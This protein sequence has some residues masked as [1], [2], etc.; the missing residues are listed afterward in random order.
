MFH[1]KREFFI[2]KGQFMVAV[3]FDS[4]DIDVLLSLFGDVR[5]QNALFEFV[6]A[7]SVGNGFLPGQLD[8]ID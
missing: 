6:S 3:K 5:C 4:E 2:P 7:G 1:F 8:F